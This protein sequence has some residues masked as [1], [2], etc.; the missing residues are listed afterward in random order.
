ME[1]KEGIQRGLEEEEKDKDEEKGE[2]EEDGE[3][4][5]EEEEGMMGEWGS[6]RRRGW[7]RSRLSFIVPQNMS[8][9]NFGDVEC[10]KTHV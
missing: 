1:E 9:F 10:K 8:S 7:R 2:E 6:R 5:G 3:E 4:D